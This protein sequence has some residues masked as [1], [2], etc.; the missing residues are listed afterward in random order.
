MKKTLG[1]FK[2]TVHTGMEIEYVRCENRAYDSKEETYTGE[3][4]ATEIPEAKR[5]TRYVSYVDTTGFYLKRPDDKGLRGSFC[6]WPKAADLEFNGDTFVIID[7]SLGNVEFQ[8]RHY[9][10]TIK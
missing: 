7:R 5:D 9:K 8:K 4:F 2:R 10:I 3:F 1:E 6:E